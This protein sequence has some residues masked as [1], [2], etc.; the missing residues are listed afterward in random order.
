MGSTP[1]PR[2][3]ATTVTSAL[4]VLAHAEKGFLECRVH[5]PEVN[6]DLWGWW[7]GGG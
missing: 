7:A 5:A 3:G 1:T 2:P 6:V 4:T